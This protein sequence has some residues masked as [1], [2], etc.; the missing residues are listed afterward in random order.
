MKTSISLEFFINLARFQTILNRKLDS[1]LGG[2]GFSEFLIL[3][4]LAST[5]DDQLRCIDL[6]NKIGL[7]ASGVTRLLLPMEKVGYI[8]RQ[9]NG[10]DARSR[11]ISLAPGGKRRL[12]EAMERAELFCEEA[13]SSDVVKKLKE[14]NSVVAALSGSIN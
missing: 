9:L 3:Y 8:K 7:T 12:E 14:F 2:L 10:Q 5:H 1:G 6:A 4:N 11:F 13:V